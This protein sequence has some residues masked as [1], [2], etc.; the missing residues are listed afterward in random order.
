MA[1]EGPMKQQVNVKLDA[2]TLAKLD[3]LVIQR[4]HEE[5]AVGKIATATRTSVAADLVREVLGGST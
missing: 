5:W 4:Q 2:A 1:C 3:A